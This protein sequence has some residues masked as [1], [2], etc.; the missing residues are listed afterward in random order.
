ML[1]FVTMFGGLGCASV[2]ASSGAGTQYVSPWAMVD[3]ARPLTVGQA[4][5]V[6]GRARASLAGVDGRTERVELA[7]GGY[8]VLRTAGTLEGG[9]QALA[10]T[11]DE[12]GSPASAETVISPAEV[13]VVGS[14]RVVSSDGKHLVVSF[15]AATD[16]SVK[17]LAVPVEGSSRTVV[18]GERTAQR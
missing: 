15:A 1:G 11:F 6:P 13:D 2:S 17:M 4:S 9:R 10:Q 3:S 14:P 8:M 7:T 16:R 18:D 12:S 5:V